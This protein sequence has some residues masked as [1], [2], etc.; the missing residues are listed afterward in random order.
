MNKQ[1]YTFACE[2]VCRSHRAEGREIW[3]LT[4]RAK[5]LPRGFKFGPNA[6]Y[7]TLDKKPAKEMLETLESDPGSFIF[8]NNGIMVVAE[9]IKASG[10]TVELVCH[11][12]ETEDE[13]PGHGVLNGGHTYKSLLYAMEHEEKFQDVGDSAYVALTVGIGIPDEEIWKISRARN[14]SEKVPLHALRELA[15]DWQ[16]LKK[17]LPEQTRVR[18]AFKPNEPGAEDADYDATDLVR[19]LALINNKMFPAEA[20]SHPVAA[21]TSIGSLVKK[22]SQQQFIE[23]APLLPDVLRLEELVVQQWEI[24]NGQKRGGSEKLGVISKASGCSNEKS[25]LL[26]G[27]TASLTL[28]DPFILP[29]IAAFRVFIKNGKWATPMEEVWEKYGPK[30]VSAL[31]D[32]YKEGGRSSA[33]YFGRSKASWAATCDLTKSV[34]IQ[35]GLIHVG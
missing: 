21:Y 10:D 7:A 5:N 22:Y 24:F 11:E 28:A 6:R 4:V 3:T 29:V 18:V 33:A 16:I 32:A 27:Y 17:Y 12:A 15:G 25:T 35:M 20:G 14:T 23:V 2:K 9:S 26:S 19:R 34:A 31:W 1:K 13:M 30:T 8:K